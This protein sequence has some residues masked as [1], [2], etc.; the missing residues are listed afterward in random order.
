MKLVS[1]ETAKRSM[2]AGLDAG[3]RTWKRVPC[4][5]A[6]VRRLPATLRGR[7]AGGRSDM[8][9]RAVERGKELH[10]D[11]APKTSKLPALPLAETAVVGACR[12]GS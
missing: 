12:I 2:K 11:F 8:Q 1:T 4:S 3:L 9:S 5:S 7:G 6:A 10:N